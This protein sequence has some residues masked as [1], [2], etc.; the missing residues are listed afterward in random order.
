M[1]FSDS[2]SLLYELCNPG[3]GS[4]LFQ[5]ARCWSQIAYHLEQNLGIHREEVKA[6]R[7]RLEMSMEATVEVVDLQAFTQTLLPLIESAL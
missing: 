1:A 3:E 6:G 5:N 7:T 2:E 4:G